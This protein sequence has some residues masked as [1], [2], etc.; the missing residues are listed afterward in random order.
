M[1]M[2]GRVALRRCRKRRRAGERR[3]ARTASAREVA[4]WM[5]RGQTCGRWGE[6]G[7]R[8]RKKRG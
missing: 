5:R 7:K 3:C 2:E 8:P 4:R 6:H 1:E